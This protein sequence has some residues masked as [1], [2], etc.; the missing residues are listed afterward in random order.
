MLST[1]DYMAQPAVPSDQ[2]VAYG[3]HADQFAD[4]YLPPGGGPHPAIILIHGGCWQAQYG[5]APLGPLC[6]A[7]R[8]TGIAVWSLE[9]RRLGGG[10]GWPTTFQDVAAGAD[11][12]RGVAADHGL[13]LDR[14][15]AAGHSAGGHL[16]L[17]LA[18]RQRLPE[19]SPLAR[20]DPL[21]IAGVLA[22]AGLVDLA[23]GAARGLCGGACLELV[24]GQGESL[25]ARYAEASPA[26]LHPL[27]VRQRH[28]VGAEDTIVPPDYLQA[29]VGRAA[30]TGDDVR[31][32]V[33]PDAGHFELVTPDSHAWP[34]VRQAIV[35]LLPIAD[36]QYKRNP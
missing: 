24:G 1:A 6:A 25:R 5:L 19:D 20:P 34:H 17:W 28:I 7:L 33:L 9:Y 23:E 2:R 21:P 11:A 3:P 15:I 36:S 29:C 13:D 8:E 22:L 35:E 4:L 27:A 30:A 14:V 31:L 26:A 12:L 10:G 16:A 32:E 18:A